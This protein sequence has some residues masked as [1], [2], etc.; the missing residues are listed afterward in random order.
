MLS[1]GVAIPLGA[2]PAWSEL[3]FVSLVIPCRNEGDYI[4]AC[5]DSILANEYPADKLE[6]LVIDGMSQDATREIVQDYARRYPQIKLVDNPKKITPAGFNLGVLNSKG[7]VIMRRD[8]HAHLEQDYIRLSVEMLQHFQ[9]DCVGGPLTTVVRNGGFFA[10]AIQLTLS[11]PF[12]VG[13]SMFRIGVKEPAWVDATA[14]G[15]FRRELLERVGP[16]NELLERSQD[17]D[18]WSRVRAH[19]GRILLHPGIRSTY[20]ARDGLLTTWIYNFSNGF[21]VTWPIR[22]AKTK[23]SLRHFIPLIFVLTLLITAAAGFLWRPFGWLG[24]VVLVAYL[25]CGFTVSLVEAFRRK[26]WALPLTGPLAFATLH[27]SYGFGSIWGWVK[28][29]R[30]GTTV[31]STLEK[32]R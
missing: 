18:F 31:P 32:T 4:A 5:L 27:F 30:F 8:A 20:V 25:F 28:P 16:Y 10:S 11:H 15:C 13:N 6:I 29:L 23:F 14:Y 22:L 9:A 21:W 26:Q 19:G 7:D 3:P 24:A 1:P 17:M 12:G 2:V